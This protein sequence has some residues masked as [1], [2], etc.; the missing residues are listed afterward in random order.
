MRKGFFIWWGSETGS[1]TIKNAQLEHAFC[2]DCMMP[3]RANL[4]FKFEKSTVYSIGGRGS[5]QEA[6]MLCLECGETHELEGRPLLEALLL[7]KKASEGQKVP[8]VDGLIKLTRELIEEEEEEKKR[9]AERQ[10]RKKEEKKKR[11][12]MREKR[13]K[14]ARGRWER[15]K[16]RVR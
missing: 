12:A 3:T 4:V 1:Y 7:F 6:H 8:K 2:P 16:A 13:A 15:L 9:Q 10:M 11:K 14:E 5:I